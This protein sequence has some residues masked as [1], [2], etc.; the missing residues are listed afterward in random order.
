MG[1]YVHGRHRCSLVKI[2]LWQNFCGENLKTFAD[3][4]KLLQWKGRYISLTI[5][6]KFVHTYASNFG[7]YICPESRTSL[8]LRAREKT[9]YVFFEKVRSTVSVKRKLRTETT[10]S[11]MDFL[12]AER[13]RQ[14]ILARVKQLKVSHPWSG[15]YNWR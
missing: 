1:T 10:M 9:Y 5:T 8:E 13:S 6:N 3:F 11:D 4:S 15:I 7:Y 2:L 14:R 12:R